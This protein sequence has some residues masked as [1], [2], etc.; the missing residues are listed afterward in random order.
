[1]TT[2]YSRAM[3]ED[4]RATQ[5]IILGR[6]SFLERCILHLSAESERMRGEIAKTQEDLLEAEQCKAICEKELAGLRLRVV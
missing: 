5:E 4:T 6:V 2:L 3:A 1:M